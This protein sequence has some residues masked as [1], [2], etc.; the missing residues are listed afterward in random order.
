MEAV[1]EE[2]QLLKSECEKI[3]NK[4]LAKNEMLKVW[5][6]ASGR[7]APLWKDYVSERNNIESQL[8]EARQQYK[9][10][11]KRTENAALSGLPRLYWFSKSMFA[12]LRKHSL[13]YQ[14]NEAR[15]KH[16]ALE[17]ARTRLVALAK[18]M[19]L[20]RSTTT[21]TILSETHLDETQQKAYSD[22]MTELWRQGEKIETDSQEIRHKLAELEIR[23]TNAASLVV[24]ASAVANDTGTGQPL[25]V[26][27]ERMLT[28]RSP[29]VGFVNKTKLMSLIEQCE[30]AAEHAERDLQKVREGLKMA[31]ESSPAG[32]VTRAT[33]DWLDY[34]KAIVTRYEEHNAEH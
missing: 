27:N 32:R 19:G 29:Y 17:A 16:E 22:S 2:P 34:C 11:L 21:E 14:V 20:D 26:E 13:Q 9:E 8:T 24:G 25:V 23:I 4:I 5:L 30:S 12:N 10:V 31:A 1:R 18:T 7:M 33:R 6:E 3:K 28:S 15:Y